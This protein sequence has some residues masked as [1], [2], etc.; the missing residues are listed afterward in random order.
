MRRRRSHQRCSCRSAEWDTIDIFP[1]IMIDLV[2]LCLYCRR[3][4]C[5]AYMIPSFYFVALIIPHLFCCPHC[6]TYLTHLCCCCLSRPEYPPPH[7]LSSLS[8]VP[9]ISHVYFHCTCQPDYPLHFSSSTVSVILH[10]CL[11][12]PCYPTSLPCLCCFCLHRSAYLPLLSPSFR[13]SVSPL[14]PCISTHRCKVSN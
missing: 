13:I 5:T 6:L 9:V 1:S 12:H 11:R 3:P 7:P 2:P 4:R 8:V 10:L 14:L